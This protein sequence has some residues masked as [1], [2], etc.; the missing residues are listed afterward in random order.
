MDDIDR[1]I[2]P[3]TLDLQVTVVQNQSLLDLSGF[4]QVV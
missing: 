3:N 4:K 1:D 2:D